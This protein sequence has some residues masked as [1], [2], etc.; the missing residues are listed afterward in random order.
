MAVIGDLLFYGVAG[1]SPLDNV[2]RYNSTER[3]RQIIEALQQ[4]EF[5]NKTD[6]ALAVELSDKMKISPLKLNIEGARPSVKDIIVD[7]SNRFEYAHSGSVPG[8]EVSKTIPFS[9]DENLWRLQ[10]NPFD[11]NPPRGTVH[12]G[13]VVIGISVPTSDV[14]SAEDYLLSTINKINEYLRRQ[15]IQITEY[16]SNIEKVLLPYLK[17]RRSRVSV[18]SDLLKRL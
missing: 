6:E 14:S 5:D 11:L 1:G 9:G 7:V 10:P 16:N 18:A 3:V 13:E 4:S 12:R 15:E 2:L 8:L 17:D